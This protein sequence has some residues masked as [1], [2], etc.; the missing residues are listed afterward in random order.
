MNNEPTKTTDR[1]ETVLSHIRVRASGRTRY[2][3]QLPFDDELMLAEIERLRAEIADLKISVIAF[4][5]PAMAEWARDFKL[6]PGHLHPVHYDILEAAGARMDSFTR[7][8][9]PDVK[10]T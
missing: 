4:G 1:L 7:A 2:E 3:G 9:L 6:P 5:G 10:R 8:E